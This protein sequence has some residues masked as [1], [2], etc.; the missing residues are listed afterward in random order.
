MTPGKSAA[1]REVFSDRRACR[2]TKGLYFRAPRTSSISPVKIYAQTESCSPQRAVWECTELFLPQCAVRAGGILGQD[3]IRAV[4]QSCRWE[5]SSSPCPRREGRSRDLSAG[6]ETSDSLFLKVLKFWLCCCAQGVQSEIRDLGKR[7]ETPAWRTTELQLILQQLQNLLYFSLKKVNVWVRISKGAS[8][9][10][11]LSLFQRSTDKLYP[12]A[13]G[14]SLPQKFTWTSKEH[15]ILPR[16]NGYKGKRWLS[17][18]ILQWAF[19][20]LQEVCREQTKKSEQ[21]KESEFIQRCGCT[22]RIHSVSS[23]TSI[24]ASGT[25]D[26]LL[27][28]FISCTERG[29]WRAT[30]LLVQILLYLTTLL[31]QKTV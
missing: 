15:E 14:R 22:F 5:F 24:R 30:M 6:P 8:Q 10:F 4:Q 28:H 11:V 26:V 21:E 17:G 19:H 13:R 31:T 2:T 20:H 7:T 9:V 23:G 25:P 3:G 1:A 27:W 16:F 18:N 12:V 29:S